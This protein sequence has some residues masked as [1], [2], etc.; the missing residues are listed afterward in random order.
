MT[1][2][3]SALVDKCSS[4]IDVVCLVKY[5]KRWCLSTVTMI[6]NIDYFCSINISMCLSQWINWREGR[7]I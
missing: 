5:L 3:F 7:A 6:L 4:L 2:E 1:N